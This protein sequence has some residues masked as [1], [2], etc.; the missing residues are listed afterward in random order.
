MR[1]L[2]CSALGRISGVVAIEACDG[3]DGLT[4]LAEIHPDV[5]MT[6][7]NMPM[8]DGFTFIERLRVLPNHDQ[9][10]II[11]LTTELGDE[12]RRRAESLGVSM[13]V[14]KPIRVRDIAAV[15]EKVSAAPTR[16]TP[17]PAGD[18]AA[19]V[20]HVVYEDI[21]ELVSDYTKGLARGEIK[22]AN[23][24]PIAAGTPVQV[25]VTFPGLAEPLFLDGEVWSTTADAE[26]T[27]TIRLASGPGRETLAKLVERV[28]PT[29]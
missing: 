10:P 22:L 21:S 14:T 15:I 1:Q 26:P 18:R 2:I 6:D 11:I 13:Y 8:M 3:A 7:L 12:D 29:S 20:L 19:V 27:L 25:A 4:K 9:T 5:I 24:R 28:R 23:R 17:R 16:P